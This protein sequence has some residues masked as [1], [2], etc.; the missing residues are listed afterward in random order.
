MIRAALIALLLA[1]PA[2]ATPSADAFAAG[3]FAEAATAGRAEATPASLVTAGRATG[4][5]AVWQ[6]R[7]K[8]RA[9]ELLGQA[10]QDLARALKADAGNLDALLQHGIVVGYIAKLEN[11]P[12]LAKQARRSFDAVLAKQP[13]DVLALGA[14]G[15]WHGESVATLGSFVAGTA[16]GAKKA[17]S[18]RF[19]NEAM[20]QNPEGASIPTFYGFTLLSLDAG[21]APQAKAL[22]ARADKAKAADGFEALMQRN[23]RE[24]LA[25]LNKGDAAAARTAARRLS[26]LGAVS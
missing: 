16:L 10:E 3:R 12:G 7:D 13:K 24:V 4:A 11:S 19:F 25:L 20:A 15:G 6:T 2:A 5:I 21:N 23:A 22:L 18:L 26:P 17:E 1:T 14:M 9:R 8:A